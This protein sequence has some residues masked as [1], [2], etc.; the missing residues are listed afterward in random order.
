MEELLELLDK[1]RHA[2][3]NLYLD[4]IA[5]FL[6]SAYEFQ[7]DGGVVID[8]SAMTYRYLIKYIVMVEQSIILPLLDTDWLGRR[9]APPRVNDIMGE[10][11]AYYT[12]RFIAHK[13]MAMAIE[14]RHGEKTAT[15]W[16]FTPVLPPYH[17]AQQYNM[18]AD[19]MYSKI[20]QLK[21]K[22]A[23]DTFNS[24]DKAVFST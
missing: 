9:S 8:Y 11:L 20:I 7:N 24:K 16:D 13:S 22:P 6:Q 4:N 1:E 18:T 5:I 12:C 15:P 10:T 19:F 21:N 3:K 17:A 14:S 23:Q 2:L